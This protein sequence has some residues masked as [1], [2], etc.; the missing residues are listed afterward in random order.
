MKPKSCACWSR[1]RSDVARLGKAAVGDGPWG[2][3]GDPGN[4]VLHKEPRLLNILPGG[5]ERYGIR[6]DIDDYLVLW[7]LPYPLACPMNIF[8]PIMCI[9]TTDFSPTDHGRIELGDIYI[10]TIFRSM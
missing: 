3:Y 10:P 7:S 6:F 8:G 4:L 9:T 5:D 1:R 2:F